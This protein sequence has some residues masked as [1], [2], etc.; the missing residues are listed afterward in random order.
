MNKTEILKILTILSQAYTNFDFG[1]NPQ[2]DKIKRD[3]WH[4]M[5]ED[6]DYKTAEKSVKKIISQN[7]FAP[8]IAEVRQAVYEVNNPGELTAGEAFEQVLSAVK[9]YVYMQEK[10]ALESLPPKTAKTVRAMGYQEICMATQVDVVRGQ[11]IKIYD[12]ISERKK[13]Q[14]KLPENLKQEIQELNQ[15]GEFPRLVKGD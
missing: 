3:L 5:L 14:E 2:Q 13:S 8:T 6:I 9:K 4:E 15:V 12:Q 10:K 1:N 11:F 7:K